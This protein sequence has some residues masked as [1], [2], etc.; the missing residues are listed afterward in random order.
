MKHPEELQLLEMLE[1]IQWPSNARTIST[2]WGTCVGA[3]YDSSGARLGKMTYQCKPLIQRMNE[4]L[5]NALKGKTLY[6]GSFQI[7]KNGVIRPHCDKNNQGPSVILFL[8]AFS[9]G[10]FRVTGSNVKRRQTVR[11]FAIDGL[12]EHYSEPFTGLRYS[13]VAF[14]HKQTKDLNERD[15]AV[16]VSMG[17]NLP[18]DSHYVGD[19]GPVITDAQAYQCCCLGVLR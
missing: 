12:T 3:T 14:L 19:G 1:A 7:N 5:K 4:V 17:F 2:G 11:F 10:A 18:P 9:G 8:G 15:K 13:I 16:L 6:W